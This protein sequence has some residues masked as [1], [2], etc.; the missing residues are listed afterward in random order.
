MLFARSAG[1]PPESWP[2]TTGAVTSAWLDTVVP[3]AADAGGVS[4]FTVEPV[5]Q[6]MIADAFKFTLSFAGDASKSRAAVVIKFSKDDAT[7]CM[8]NLDW[9]Q[10]EIMYYENFAKDVPIKC[11]E[12]FATF[13]NDATGEHC[14]VMEDCMSMPGGEVTSFPMWMFGVE[15]DFLTGMVCDLAKMNGAFVN[16]PRLDDE[17]MKVLN[18]PEWMTGLSFQPGISGA[19]NKHWDPVSKANAAFL[20]C[21]ED[22]PNHAAAVK[23]VEQNND[24]FKFK[25][26]WEGKEYSAGDDGVPWAGVGGTD[27]G[28]GELGKKVA[29][30]ILKKMGSRKVQT[31]IHG[32]GHPGNVFYQEETKKFT[33]IDF[34]AVHK[35]PPGWE[36]SQGLP[37]AMKGADMAMFKRVVATY[38]ATFLEAAPAGTAELYTEDECWEDFMLGQFLW[39]LAYTNISMQALPAIAQAPDDDPMLAAFR[40]LFPVSIYA[41]LNLGFEGYIRAFMEAEGVA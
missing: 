3:G 38:Y 39:Q 35:G 25:Y 15:E 18:V 17:S 31:M 23:A 33:W 20:S 19:M 4:S 41:H 14:I 16:D 21:P 30:A 6:G 40:V 29:V 34:Q 9:Y 24:H 36:L 5:G 26:S 13:M 22:T 11:A 28:Q 12:T 27:F 2:A 7:V 10:R 1:G 32:D 8:E 37:L